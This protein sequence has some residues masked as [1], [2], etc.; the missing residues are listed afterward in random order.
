MITRIMLCIIHCTLHTCLCSEIHSASHCVYNTLRLFKYFLLHEVLIA[1]CIHNNT[2]NMYR[3]TVLH[4]VYKVKQVNYL[5]L[6]V[7]M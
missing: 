6:V 2:M 7:Y 4:Y 3:G 1:T 5:K